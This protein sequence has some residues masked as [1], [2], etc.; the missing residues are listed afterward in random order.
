MDSLANNTTLFQNFVDTAVSD[1]A[2]AD[3]KSMLENEIHIA[4]EDID[5]IPDQLEVLFGISLS[6]KEAKDEA[7]KLEDPEGK[8]ALQ[9]EVEEIAGKLKGRL[10]INMLAEAE[11]DGIEALISEG[12]IVQD[13]KEVL[14]LSEPISP[15]TMFTTPIDLQKASYSVVEDYPDSYGFVDTVKNWYKI[16]KR[17]KYAEYVHASGSV[18]KMDKNGNTTIE[19]K[20]KLKLIQRGEVTHFI[21]DN[22]DI[23][24]DGS[25]YHHILGE[26]KQLIDGDHTITVGGNMKT[27]ATRIDLN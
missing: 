11:A 4:K 18:L 6:D 24:I 17:K 9:K 12:H 27:T 23:S 8:T 14:E 1:T 13:S 3:F 22:L 25:F 15:D 19:I 10:Q 5:K 26:L 20:G 7:E 21:G 16:N 2:L